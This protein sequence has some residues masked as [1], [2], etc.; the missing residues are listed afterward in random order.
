MGLSYTITV[1]TF[2][3]ATAIFMHGTTGVLHIFTVDQY[4]TAKWLNDRKGEK[5]TRVERRGGVVEC[6]WT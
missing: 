3:V 4:G 2:F 6:V 5:N 1:K